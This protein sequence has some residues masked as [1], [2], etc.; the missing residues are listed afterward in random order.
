MHTTTTPI[1]KT[2]HQSQEA[3]RLGRQGYSIFIAGTKLEKLTQIM[4]SPHLSA[5]S[6]IAAA[7]SVRSLISSGFAG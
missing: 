5:W 1:P 6:A 4:L 2:I 7:L 3:L